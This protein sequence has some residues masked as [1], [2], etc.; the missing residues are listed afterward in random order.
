MAGCNLKLTYQKD[1]KEIPLTKGAVALVDDADYEHLMQWSWCFDNGYAM[2]GFLNDNRKQVH[3]YMHH[4]LMPDIEFGVRVVD[5]QD[6]NK[7]NNQRH[8]LRYVTQKQNTMNRSPARANGL[9]GVR[10]I[11]RNPANPYH[12]Y[13]SVNRKQKHLGYFP[14]E[15]EAAVAYNTAALSLPDSEYRVLNKT[16]I[17][18][19]DAV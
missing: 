7:L 8:N 17:P 10:F 12:A 18:E 3:R 19:P 13:I 6:R 9:V 14:T 16:F 15:I 1:M 5:H 4:E 2:R 11:A